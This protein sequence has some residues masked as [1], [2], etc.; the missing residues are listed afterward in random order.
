M[1]RYQSLLLAAFAFSFAAC[2][3]EFENEVNNE[4]Y[5]SGEADFTTYVAVGNSLTAGYM[6]GTVFKSGQQNSFPNLL[7]KQFSIVGGGHFSQ[8]SFADDANDLGGLLFNGQ[9]IQGFPTRMAILMTAESSGPVNLSGT[10]S[11]EV[12][13]LQ[14][15]AYNNMGVPGAKSFHLVVP[16]YGN[17]A[18]LATGRANPYFVRHATS[19][20]A[21]ILKNAIDR[22]STRL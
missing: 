8:P 3:P 17:I 16:G 14:Q 15:T 7:A 21:T 11:I 6:D 4:T 20:Q 19:P 2:E 18:A 10:P 12:S 22:K 9:P 5:S 13:D 1:K